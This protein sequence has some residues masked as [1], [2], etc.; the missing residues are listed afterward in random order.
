MPVTNEFGIDLDHR[1]GYTFT[2]TLL[3]AQ[4]FGAVR[5]EMTKRGFHL[6][7][8][9]PE[10]LSLDK[11]LNIRRLLGDCEGR[12]E[13]DEFRLRVKDYSSFDTLFTEKRG[14]KV[15]VIEVRW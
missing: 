14:H 13:Y 9:M 4:R 1:D 5:P 10:Y 3:N 8:T 15:E 12:L 2:C 6:T 7:V 11:V